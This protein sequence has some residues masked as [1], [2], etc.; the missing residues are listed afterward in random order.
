M[1]SHKYRF[2]GHGSLRY[3]YRNGKSARSRLF[4]L[5]YTPN[6]QRVHSR[7]AVIVSK[8]VMKS[9]VGRNRMRRR[10]FEILRHEWPELKGGMDIALSVYS[11][12][13]MTMPADELR[14]QVIEVLRSAN[15]YR[16]Q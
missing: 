10:L 12:E 3:L 13:C 6:T 4:L 1:L 14:R 11:A 9:A 8:K 2:H 5:R 7:A 16:E 15:L